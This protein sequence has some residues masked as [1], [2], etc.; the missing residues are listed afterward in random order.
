MNQYVSIRNTK[1]ESEI[2]HLMNLLVSI[3]SIYNRILI[4]MFKY[5]IFLTQHLFRYIGSSNAK[6][7]LYYIL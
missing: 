7:K 4:F 6:Y 2:Q 1:R 5:H 3:K